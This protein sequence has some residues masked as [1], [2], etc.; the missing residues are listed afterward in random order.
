MALQFQIV[1]VPRL[2]AVIISEYPQRPQFVPDDAP[3]GT[4]YTVD[5]FTPE[6]AP[7]GGRCL[8][9]LKRANDGK[10]VIPGGPDK[11]GDGY[12]VALSVHQPGRLLTDETEPFDT[13]ESLIDVVQEV[14]DARV[15]WEAAHQL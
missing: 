14:R 9:V 12:Y 6:L 8:L 5:Y 13:I 11:N 7:Y 15:A 1:P 4:Y 2:Q 3:L 10:F